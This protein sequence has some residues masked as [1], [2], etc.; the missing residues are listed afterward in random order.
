MEI[1]RVET[2]EFEKATQQQAV[3][4]VCELSE[5]QLTLVGGGIADVVFA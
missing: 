5:L 2:V 3:N 4:E 1:T